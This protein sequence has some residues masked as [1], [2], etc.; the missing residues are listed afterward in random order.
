[1][2]GRFALSKS[3][4]IDWA[5]FGVRRGPMLPPHWNIGPG[6][7][8]AAVRHGDQGIEAAMLRWGLIPFWAKDPSIGNRLSNARAESVHEKPS[9][10]AAF[11][12]RRCLIPADGFYEWQATGAK[13]KQPWF[14][15]RRDGDVFAIAGLWERWTP[16]TGDAVESC[17][18][19]TM[20]ANAL[21]APIHERMP[22]II[23]PSDY[24]AW[25]SPDTTVAR[26]QQLL[27][28]WA[29]TDWTA[30]R[31]STRVNAPAHDDAA[32]V[33]P[34]ADDASP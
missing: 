30:H 22:V 1:M 16:T 18:V 13:K 17:A 20:H 12:T 2:C 29:S 27:A 28:P 5:Q 19:L 15:S 4:R 14:V 8:V 7:P 11:S 10:R 24:A 33:A 21:M 6:R 9:F 32:C 26:A 23:T 31:V 34:L 25:L 3:D